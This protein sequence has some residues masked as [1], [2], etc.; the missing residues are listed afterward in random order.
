MPATCACIYSMKFI[1]CMNEWM[2]IALLHATMH[3]HPSHQTNLKSMCQC[4][5]RTDDEALR[6]ISMHQAGTTFTNIEVVPKS[7]FGCGDPCPAPGPGHRGRYAC[8]PARGRRPLEVLK[9]VTSSSAQTFPAGWSAAFA[10]SARQI[11]LVACQ[12]TCMQPVILHR[13]HAGL[14]VCSTCE[15]I[16]RACL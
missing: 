14:G 6:S 4:Y 5:G 16:H 3:I 7:G 2:R 15:F 12:C 10:T 8:H 1:R 9:G 13:S 11:A